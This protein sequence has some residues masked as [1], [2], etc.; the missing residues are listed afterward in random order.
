[1]PI[2]S[3][4]LPLLSSWRYVVVLMTM[5]AA[6]WM[7]VDRVCFSI[8]ADPIRGSLG[9]DAQPMSY[10]LGAFFFGVYV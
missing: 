3:D 7:Y 8:L 5:L 10:V 9:I 4:S 6:L 1:M 2:A